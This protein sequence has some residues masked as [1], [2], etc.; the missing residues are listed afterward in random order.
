[1]GLF[2]SRG[3]ESVYVLKQKTRELVQAMYSRVMSL[4]ERPRMRAASHSVLGHFPRAGG[5]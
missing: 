1:M 2:R 3:V 5:C 4:R